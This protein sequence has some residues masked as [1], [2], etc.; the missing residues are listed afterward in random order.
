M[1]A[2]RSSSLADRV[3]RQ[4]EQETGREAS[5]DDPEYAAYVQRALPAM[6]AADKAAL[7][8]SQQRWK[9]ADKVAWAAAAIP[10]A[11][12]AAP[13]V[14]GAFSGAAPAASVPGVVSG[15]PMTAAGQAAALGVGG[16]PTVLGGGAALAS[17]AAPIAGGGLAATVPSVSSA[18][19]GSGM[20]IPWF[21][22]GKEVVKG[23]FDFFGGK[24]A[25]DSNDRASEALERT[26]A[27]ELD[28]ER[29]KETRRQ[30]EY[31]AAEEAKKRNFDIEQQEKL[32]DLRRLEERELQLEPARIAKEAAYRSYMQKYWGIDVGASVARTPRQI[33]TDVAA[34]KILNDP[35]QLVKKQDSK[36]LAAQA[37]PGAGYGLSP[38]PTIKTEQFTGA[39]AQ[40]ALPQQGGLPQPARLPANPEDEDEMQNQGTSFRYR[41]QYAPMQEMR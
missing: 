4:F 18:A 35:N 21:D 23:A 38:A 10:F 27:A 14:A 12:A 6:V 32:E 7:E 9:T 34:G 20:G 40:A 39:P 2:G 30:S 24:K 13:V 28:F 33:A 17:T 29:E 41:R 3:G 11:A 36:S 1:A 16:T 37:N 15:A 31:D 22:V 19:G 26:S 8:R 5:A 25:A